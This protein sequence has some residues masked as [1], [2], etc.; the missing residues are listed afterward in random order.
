MEDWSK[1]EELV[2]PGNL[3]GLGMTMDPNFTGLALCLGNDVLNQY[4]VKIS[5]LR[6]ALRSFV[7]M[8][9]L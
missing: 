6:F 7:N 8:K 4:T 2:T 5:W 9:L 1:V 3:M